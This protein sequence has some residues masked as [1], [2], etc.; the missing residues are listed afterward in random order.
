M[1][2]LHPLLDK[3]TPSCVALLRNQC[4]MGSIMTVTMK[5]TKREAKY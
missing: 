2:C 3:K 4:P 1:A 5:M